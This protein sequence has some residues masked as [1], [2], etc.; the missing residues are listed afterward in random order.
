M[1]DLLFKKRKP[2]PTPP[3][4]AWLVI[5]VV[6]YALFANQ[7]KQ[8]SNEQPIEP[9]EQSSGAISEQLAPF[10]EIKNKLVP[11]MKASLRVQEL[12]EGKGAP[13]VCGQQVRLAYVARLSEEKLI[14]DQKTPDAPLAFT[15]GEGKV[16]P[17]LERGV[18]GMKA[19]GK[20]DVIASSDLAYDAEGFAQK[21]VPT[22]SAIKFSLELISAQPEMPATGD[23]AF[24]IIDSLQGSGPMI[25]CGA[26][27]RA[28]IKVQDI[29]GKTLYDSQKTGAA[30]E[31]TPGKSEVFIGLEQGVV[32][33]QPRGE[34]L[35]V[36]PPEFQKT[37]KGN[38][39]TINIP[40]PK[41]EIALVEV[42]ALP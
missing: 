1:F 33:M 20:R 24:R 22:G 25:L 2:R 12:S 16:M 11:S 35:L 19:G 37:M 21:D 13:A 27:T 32:G 39:P 23:T 9:L 30:L 5:G 15:I 26:T 29:R 3:W 4:A 6:M 8:P 40:L 36:V 31:F 42:T 38:A 18:I 7:N 10:D 14:N 41:N 34:R 28:H 17:A